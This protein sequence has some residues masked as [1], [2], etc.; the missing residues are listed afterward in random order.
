MR[1]EEPALVEA[2]RMRALPEGSCDKLL[3][4]LRLYRNAVQMIVDKIWS[5]DGRLSKRKLHRLFYSNL[6]SM[7]F[8]AHHAKEVY[9]YAESLVE[10]ARSNGGRKPILRKLSARIDRYDYK[11]DLDTMTLALKLHS[12]Y[13]AK[14]K[15]VSS[16]ER[17]GKFRGWG[18]YEL[19]VKYDGSGFWVSIYFRRAVKA[20]KPRTVMSIDLNFDNI[21]LA[22]LTLDGRLAKLKRFRTPHRKVLTHRIWVERVQRRYP[23]SWR[24]IKSV[25][26]AI[27]RHGERVKNISWGY[28]HKVGDLVAGLASKHSSIIVLEDLDKL[29]ENNKRGREFNKRLGLWI[30]RRIQFCIE[31]EAKERNLEVVK[32]NPRGTSSK[33]PRCGK[34]L[35]KNKHRILRCRKCG[36]VGDRDVIAVINLYKKYVSKYS[37][38]GV[39]GVALNAPKPDENPSGVQRNRDDAMKT[40]LVI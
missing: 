18:N 19:V 27:D 36:F 11:L 2:L 14:L 12:G 4:F 25:R 5:I 21:T 28:A 37:R 22:V 40:H 26:K 1:G 7:G 38:C 15:L 16:S 23:R 13:E 24:F 17:V 9:V 31:Y 39:S 3:E 6:V 33:C 30:Y 8:R 29:R 20:V 34:K 32:I 35:A 10:S